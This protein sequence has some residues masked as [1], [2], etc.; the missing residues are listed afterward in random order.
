LKKAKEKYL[1]KY[2]NQL[3][4]IIRDK[5]AA[6]GQASINSKMAGFEN[7]LASLKKSGGSRKRRISRKARRSH[8]RRA[9]TAG[10]A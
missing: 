5:T 4:I 1:I 10:K 6:T 3:Y 7:R 9:G 2:G 8:K